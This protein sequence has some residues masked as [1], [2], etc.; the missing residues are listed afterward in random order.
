MNDKKT[1]QKDKILILLN[2]KI[3][4]ELDL[5]E[6]MLRYKKLLSKSPTPIKA[7]LVFLNSTNSYHVYKLKSEYKKNKMNLVCPECDGNELSKMA[8]KTGGI[9]E[10][11]ASGFYK[12]QKCQSIVP[13]YFVISKPGYILSDAKKNWFEIYKPEQIDLDKKK[14]LAE[15]EGIQYV[16]EDGN[17]VDP[18]EI[19]IDDLNFADEWGRDVN[20][21]GE[22]LEPTLSEKN[23]I[24]AAEKMVKYNEISLLINHCQTYLK[25][26]HY[27]KSSQLY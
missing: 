23:A 24:I 4:D 1:D 10:F 19:D 9:K 16:D 15:V 22:L 18:S 27:P 25:F 2:E 7:L 11:Q 26:E 6:T 8:Q 14:K 5:A 3:I 20:Y 21:K 13:E 12:C 17:P